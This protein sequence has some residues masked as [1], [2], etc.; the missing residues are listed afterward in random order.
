MPA[1]QYNDV[2][3]WRQAARRRRRDRLWRTVAVVVAVGCFVAAVLVAT[4]G[5][6]QPDSEP[7]TLLCHATGSVTSPYVLLEIP[8][9]FLDEHRIHPEDIIPAPGGICPTGLQ[10]PTVPTE[11]TPTETTPTEI[12]PTETTPTETTPTETTPTETTPTETKPEQG[13][14]GEETGPPPPLTPSPPPGTIRPASAA[15]LTSTAPEL[16][17]TGGAPLAVG[18]LGAGLLLLGAGMR[19]RT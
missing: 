19:P 16:A 3:E 6:Q 4:A 5:A 13:G 9:R 1:R 14:D 10:T 18:L 2:S 7:S 17:R 15:P 12:S 11:T 8:D